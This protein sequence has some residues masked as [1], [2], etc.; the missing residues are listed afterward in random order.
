MRITSPDHNPGDSCVNQGLSTGWSSA[1]ESARF[2]RD[3]DSGPGHVSAGIGDC[4]Y[5]RMGF[6]GLLM[7]STADNLTVA[8]NYAAYRRIGCTGIATMDSKL[9][10][11][12]YKEGVG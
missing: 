6:A 5:F 4:I 12:S 7:V 1:H 2:Q 8:N 10:G 9:Q 3:I 11:R